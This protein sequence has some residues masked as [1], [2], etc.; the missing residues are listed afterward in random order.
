[1]LYFSL[2]TKIGSIE[3]LISK[4]KFIKIN[5]IIHLN[6]LYEN[7]SNLKVQNW[8]LKFAPNK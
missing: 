6:F 4:F 2:T 8:I 1:M 7:T 3:V 5:I